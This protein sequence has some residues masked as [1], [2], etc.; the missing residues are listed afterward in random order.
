V[1]LLDRRPWAF[2]VPFGVLPTGGDQAGP[3]PGVPEVIAGEPTARLELT[4][5][6]AS[7]WRVTV[8]TAGLPGASGALTVRELGASAAGT[9]S[10]WTG[11]DLQGAEDMP[12]ITAASP[13]FALCCHLP[14]GRYILVGSCGAFWRSRGIEISLT[15]PGDLGSASAIVGE[16]TAATGW[17]T[18]RTDGGVGVC[19]LPSGRLIALVKRTSGNGDTRYSDDGGETWQDL[20]TNVFPDVFGGDSSK[21]I[22]LGAIGDDL[23]AF[24]Q[25]DVST[26]NVWHFASTDGGA[27]FALVEPRVDLE[28][29]PHL[30]PIPGGL[31]YFAHD[32][33]T[34]TTYYQRLQGVWDPIAGIERQ[35]V[36]ERPVGFRACAGWATLDGRLYC[37]EDV[38]AAIY[39]SESVDG[40]VTWAE[41]PHSRLEHPDDGWTTLA[42][43]WGP[44]GALVAYVP[45]HDAT[46]V[47]AHRFGGWSNRQRSRPVS[48]VGWEV[49]AWPWDT[50]DGQGWTLTGSGSESLVGASWRI[51]GDLD[52]SYPLGTETRNHGLWLDFKATGGAVGTDQVHL[53]LRTADGT[54][55]QRL[56]MRFFGAN[57]WDL[58]DDL[59]NT[60]LVEGDENLSLRVQMVLAGS[61]LLLRRPGALAWTAYTFTASSE[62]SA[63]SGLVVWSQTTTSSWYAWGLNAEIGDETV[64]ADGEGRPVGGIGD[65]L[66][67]LAG[68]D[69][70][71]LAAHGGTLL[72]GQS[73]EI[74]PTYRFG[75]ELTGHDEPATA[76]WSSG[77]NWD[78]VLTWDLGARGLAAG[79]LIGLLL[80]RHR[81][82][83]LEVDH[84]TDGTTWTAAADVD[85]LGT[86][87]EAAA[88]AGR[89]IRPTA[90]TADWGRY[91]RADELVGG[92]VLIDGTD[93][94]VIVRNS[95][96]AWAPDAAVGATITL[97]R[98]VEAAAAFGVHIIPPVAF[99]CFRNGTGARYWRVTIPEQVVPDEAIGGKLELGE[100]LAIG[101]VPDRATSRVVERRLGGGR[102]VGGMPRGYEL[103]PPLTSWTWSWVDGQLT[104]ELGEGDAL[105]VDG[106]SLVDQD[107]VA[108]QLTAVL[109]RVGAGVVVAIRELPDPEVAVTDP[110]RVML[111][112][113]EGVVSQQ[114]F[115]TDAERVESITLLEVP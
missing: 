43:A 85:L 59:T 83:V 109:R 61:R 49:Y 34:D 41:A 2:M 45:V 105:G 40:G 114:E 39:V 88:V 79:R 108:G 82:A 51:A 7:S 14:T 67:S 99:V 80:R 94:A 29:D 86:E 110:A 89:T 73:W 52:L 26:G 64:G 4:G 65:W 92:W 48:P 44:S 3:G 36:A 103:G 8:A 23:C 56:K 21:R 15:G 38:G 90:T 106:L 37:I 81:F 54:R 104:H 1:A 25:K 69:A 76:A 10:A 57:G 101:E 98:D 70:S 63:A 68:V 13:R 71:R 31:G 66:P 111:A 60:L 97:D 55:R 12:T 46:A 32:A 5:R 72:Q 20:A 102:D 113:L 75:L 47:L 18:S 115:A 50:L 11:A 77:V 91:L 58:Y 22:T 9:L 33:N 19:C 107:D 27:T 78:Q 30:A 74:E 17:S 96:G 53:Q 35:V 28:V 100:V 112:T 16:W 24:V 84:S 87:V 6:Q 93:A 42:T 62:L 95:A